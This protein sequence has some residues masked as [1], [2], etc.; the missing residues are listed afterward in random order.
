MTAND[1]FIPAV[2]FRT[3]NMERRET[4]YDRDEIKGSI[5][6]LAA[7]TEIMEAEIHAAVLACQPARVQAL[8]GLTALWPTQ[9]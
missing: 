4:P 7:M 9:H 8:P 1:K 2:S 6:N 5:Q 3:T